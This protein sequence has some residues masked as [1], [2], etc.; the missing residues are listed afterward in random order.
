MTEVLSKAKSCFKFDMHKNDEF[1][2]LLKGLLEKKCDG[3]LSSDIREID[4]NFK[5]NLKKICA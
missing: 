3:L 2:L 5:E 4:Y 1:E